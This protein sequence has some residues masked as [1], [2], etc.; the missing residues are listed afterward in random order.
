M[1]DF[2][3]IINNAIVTHGALHQGGE[4]YKC[5]EFLHDKKLNGFIE[6]GSANGGSFF[7]WASIIDGPKISVDLNHGFGLSDGLPGA[8]TF[9][10][11]AAAYEETNITVR[12][13]ND[14]WRKNFSDVRIIEGNSMSTVTIQKVSDCLHGD[15]VGWIFIDAWHEY[16]AAMEDLKNFKQFLSPNGYIGFH[17]I[18]QSDSMKKF[19]TDITNTYSNTITI[20][21]SNGIG[22]I[23]AS[24]LKS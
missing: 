14:K 18:H 1:I 12:I 19:W 4:M 20:P 10:D 7:C 5:L 23:P 3:N 24:S 16:F 9:D 6:V 13:R 21:E 11:V 8:N 17:D 15:L 2:Q 22:I